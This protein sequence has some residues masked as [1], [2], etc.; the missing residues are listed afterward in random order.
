[1]GEESKQ[2]ER[3]RSS[4]PIGFLDVT[5]PGEMGEVCEHYYPFRSVL[6]R[7][8][9]ASTLSEKRLGSLEDFPVPAL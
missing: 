3:V 2:E 4:S 5:S 6:R 8:P 9:K 7:G 1:M